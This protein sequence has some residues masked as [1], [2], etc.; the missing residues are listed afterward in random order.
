MSNRTLLQPGRCCE[1][2]YNGRVKTI[3]FRQFR[4]GSRSYCAK[5]LLQL[6][7]QCRFDL[8]LDS[9]LDVGRYHICWSARPLKCLGTVRKLATYPWHWLVI[10]P[11]PSITSD[12][13]GP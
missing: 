1:T 9:T 2:R 10:G 12:S 6:T 11:S 5:L 4:R 13:P 3:T 7:L 8:L